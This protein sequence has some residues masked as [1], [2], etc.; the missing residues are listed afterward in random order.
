MADY[1]SIPRAASGWLKM[2]W[3]ILIMAVF[4]SRKREVTKAKQGA[5]DKWHIRESAD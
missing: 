5:K 3:H 4:P 1:A 2:G